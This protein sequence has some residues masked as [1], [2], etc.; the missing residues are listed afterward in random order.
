[1]VESPIN[2]TGGASAGGVAAAATSTV[3]IRGSDVTNPAVMT[4][5]RGI[6]RHECNERFEVVVVTT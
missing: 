5:A 4:V 6:H 2:D 3:E 1:M